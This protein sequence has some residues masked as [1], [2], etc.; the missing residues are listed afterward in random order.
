MKEV[1]DH[2]MLTE[3]EQIICNLRSENVLL[4]EKILILDAEGQKR[5]SVDQDKLDKRFKIV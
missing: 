2:A 1:I 3:S 5:L 4:R